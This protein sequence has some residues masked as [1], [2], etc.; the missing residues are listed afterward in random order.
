MSHELTANIDMIILNTAPFSEVVDQYVMRK[1]QKYIGALFKYCLNYDTS[2]IVSDDAHISQ[3]YHLNDFMRGIPSSNHRCYRFDR[4]TSKK[5]TQFTILF[6]GNHIKDGV[7]ALSLHRERDDLVMTQLMVTE[8]TFIKF[9]KYY[10]HGSHYHC[11]EYEEHIPHTQWVNM[12]ERDLI[13]YDTITVMEWS[14]LRNQ[15]ERH[16]RVRYP[17]IRHMYVLLDQLS[18][19]IARVQSKVLLL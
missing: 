15:T 19:Q 13:D 18:K 10:F 11:V 12:Y 8:P 17:T 6:D 9:R 7:F 16:I 3:K 4:S 5:F 14:T 1:I 2:I